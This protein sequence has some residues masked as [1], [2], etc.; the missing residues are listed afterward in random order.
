MSADNEIY[1]I[2]VPMTRK[3]IDTLREQAV[4]LP[5]GAAWESLRIHASLP[6]RPYGFVKWLAS[7]KK[8]QRH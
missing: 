8:A 4:L 6:G 2:E 5:S 7:K 1:W 3:E